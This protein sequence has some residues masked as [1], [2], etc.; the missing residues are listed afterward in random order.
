[1]NDYDGI[2]RSPHYFKPPEK[3]LRARKPRGPRKEKREP[4]VTTQLFNLV[5]ELALEHRYVTERPVEPRVRFGPHLIIEGKRCRIGHVQKTFSPKKGEKQYARGRVTK[6]A[7]PL[8]D[9]HVFVIEVD[10]G[11]PYVYIM[12]SMVVHDFL[13]AESGRPSRKQSNAVQVLNFPH[14]INP[15]SRFEHY[16][17]AWALL[18]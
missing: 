3:E 15:L 1:M 2:R 6:T 11:K 8:T 5:S 10:A 12:P 17:N 13:F 4:K 14:P 16:R 9:Y 7:L 18:A